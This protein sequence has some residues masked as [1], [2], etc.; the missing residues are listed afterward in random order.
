MT[1]NSPVFWTANGLSLHTMAWSVT[2]FSGQRHVGPPKRGE[3][4]TMPFRDGDMYIPKKRASRTFDISMW[5]LPYHPDGGRDPSMSYE[6]RAHKNY[7]TIIRAVDVEGQFNL[8]K[9]WWEDG[10]V[11]LATARAELI[12]ATSASQDDALGFDMQIQL[13]LAD[14]YF[15][16]SLTLEENVSTMN[17][18]V[19]DVPTNHVLL[20]I[21]P[22]ATVTFPDGNWIKYNATS[23]A[24]AVFDLSNMTAKVGSTYVNGKISRNYYLS[25]PELEPGDELT[26]SGGSATIQYQPAY[27]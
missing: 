9:R 21:D 15:Y 13:A 18:A 2:S 3:D 19:G 24:A 5:V 26:V 7:L 27:R 20:K 16:G 25:W 8:V 6:Q 11:R 12:S 4:V 10:T 17:A 23:G 14:P 1:N 22:G